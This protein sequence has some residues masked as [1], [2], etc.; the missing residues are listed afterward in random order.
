[1]AA[2]VFAYPLLKQAVMATDFDPDHTCVT[3]TSLGLSGTNTLILI[4]PHQQLI[5][6]VIAIICTGG[7]GIPGF[8]HELI[9]RTDP[10]KIWQSMIN[11]IYYH[12]YPFAL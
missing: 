5:E 1:M 3:T 10:D 4:N 8:L 9:E 7:H 6:A 11:N 12:F 2:N